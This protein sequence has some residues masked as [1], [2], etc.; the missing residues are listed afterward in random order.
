M[1]C[2]MR[3]GGHLSKTALMHALSPLASLPRRGSL[4]MV[5]LR[6]RAAFLF[7][8]RRCRGVG[9][10]SISFGG[11]SDGPASAGG[12]G[13]GQALW[14]EFWRVA[15]SKASGE[16]VG[17]RLAQASRSKSR[18]QVVMGRSHRGATLILC[19]S[20]VQCAASVEARS[21][22]RYVRALRRGCLIGECRVGFAH[23]SSL[24]SKK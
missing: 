21:A 24:S 4:V 9:K 14:M 18:H 16:G 12:G 13:R 5:A 17:G 11:C 10:W 23:L 15:L 1:F 22:R 2:V 19:R 8:D 3:R 6:F 7:S 20:F